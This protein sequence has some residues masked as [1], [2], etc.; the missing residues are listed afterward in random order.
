MPL[1]EDDVPKWAK[2]FIDFW[3]DIFAEKMGTEHINAMNKLASTLKLY[4]MKMYKI[5]IEEEKTI[6]NKI[7]NSLDGSTGKLLGIPS[8]DYPGFMVYSIPSDE[9]KE[10][11]Q[12]KG[13]KHVKNFKCYFIYPKVGKPLLLEFNP[14]DASVVGAEEKDFPAGLAGKVFPDHKCP[15]CGKQQCT[16]KIEPYTV[17]VNEGEK[18]I[19]KTRVFLTAHCESD[20]CKTHSK[21]SEQD[22]RDYMRQTVT[23]ACSAP[24]PLKAAGPSP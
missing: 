1:G 19:T 10:Y 15:R 14:Y 13:E 23:R 6:L 7:Y 22:I 5:K 4:K 3:I 20:E 18:L 12:Y 9:H 24:Q 16:V 11:K 8:S 2:F 21:V 17:Q